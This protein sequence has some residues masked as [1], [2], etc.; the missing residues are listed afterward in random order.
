VQRH[1]AG[2]IA[3]VFETLQTFDEHWGDITLGDCADDAT[4]GKPPK[5][6]NAC[7]VEERKRNMLSKCD[8]F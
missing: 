8:R 4:H 3:A 1:A 5:S 6:M 2:I 7:T